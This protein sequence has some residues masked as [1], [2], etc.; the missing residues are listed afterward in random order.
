MTTVVGPAGRGRSDFFILN[1]DIG[2]MLD[3]KLDHCPMAVVRRVVQA[4]ARVDS[5]RARAAQ[6]FH[7][8]VTWQV[9]VIFS[10]G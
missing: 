4:C 8:P 5:H 9:R 3:E 6:K 1:I 7:F 2:A 10:A